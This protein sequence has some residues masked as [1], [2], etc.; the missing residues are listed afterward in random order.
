VDIPG[1]SSPLG[2]GWELLTEVKD[3]AKFSRSLELSA[4]GHGFD[5][6]SNLIPLLCPP[7]DPTLPAE[8][9]LDSGCSTPRGSPGPV[10]SSG[11]SCA[12]G[13]AR[14]PP[15][16]SRALGAG[17]EAHSPRFW[18]QR[19]TSLLSAGGHS[20]R[21]TPRAV[22]SPCHAGASGSRARAL[23]PRSSSHLSKLVEAA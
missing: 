7:T 12:A 23:E 15:D 10:S 17:L 11:S 22:Q 1:L 5:P 8:A 4:S 9:G 14:G 13:P 18:R 19:L 3:S 16:G 6:A 20:V 2:S 21:S